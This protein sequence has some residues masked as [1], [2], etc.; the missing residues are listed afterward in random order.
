MGSLAASVLT[1]SL[2]ILAKILLARFQ[3]QLIKSQYQSTFLYH[4]ILCKG[5]DTDANEDVGAEPNSKDDDTNQGLEMELL[6]VFDNLGEYIGIPRT[7]ISGNDAEKKNWLKK[8]L[9]LDTTK[10]LASKPRPSFLY[11]ATSSLN[12]FSIFPFFI[13]VVVRFSRT[14]VE[15]GWVVMGC[16]L[17]MAIT[18]SCVFW[19][20]NAL[21]AG[22]GPGLIYGAQE[23]LEAGLPIGDYYEPIGDAESVQSELNDEGA[24]NQTS[25]HSEKSN[26]LQESTH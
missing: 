14:P 21:Y 4:R 6:D 20:N 5:V 7:V 3:T 12:L 9:L 25:I 11:I 24:P 19:T 17:L 22:D 10:S 23:D 18:V 26:L 2:S 8:Q 13:G 15:V 16:F 1:L